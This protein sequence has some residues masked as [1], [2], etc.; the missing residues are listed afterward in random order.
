MEGLTSGNKDMTTQ[1]MQI[2]EEA[3]R[4]AA[5]EAAIHCSGRPVA[6][7]EAG[8]KLLVIVPVV[9]NLDILEAPDSTVSCRQS[10]HWSTTWVHC[11]FTHP[12][13][14]LS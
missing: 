7:P 10:Y 1:V 4:K 9:N 8:I 2:A 13:M 5:D 12:L 14:E 6:C 11:L 3:A